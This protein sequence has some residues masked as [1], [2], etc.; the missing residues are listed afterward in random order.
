MILKNKIFCI[1]FL[2]LCLVGCK[3][4]D[5]ELIELHKEIYQLAVE[6][7]Y[8]GTYEEWIEST[9]GTQY[10]AGEDEKNIEITV[11]DG[12]IKWRYDGNI[13]W[14]NLLSL[15]SLIGNYESDENGIELYVSSTHIQ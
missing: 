10:E 9:K 7:G 15:E 4:K 11:N 1:L 6:V 14:N 2:L 5:D 8:E 12:Y 3:N 13:I